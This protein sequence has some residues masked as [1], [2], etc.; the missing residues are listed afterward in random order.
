M[1]NS[2]LQSTKVFVTVWFDVGTVW[3]PAG[4]VGSLC[5]AP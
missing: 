4:V 5:P 1:I 3:N 2:K